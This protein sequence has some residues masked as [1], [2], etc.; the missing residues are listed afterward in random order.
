MHLAE[1]CIVLEWS[2]WERQ[3]RG[4]VKKEQEQGFHKIR[5]MFAEWMK[6]IQDWIGD[7]VTS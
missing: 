1:S 4:L 2:K 5:L 6:G 7:K 3:L